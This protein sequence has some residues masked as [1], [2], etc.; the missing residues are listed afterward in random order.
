MEKKKFAAVALDPQYEIFVVYIASLNSVAF[1]S[2]TPLDADIHLFYSNK[3]ADLIAEKALTKVLA[4]YANFTNV[5]SLDLASK[6]PK[7]NR[8]N[9]STI[10]QVNGQKPSSR[11]IYSRRLV[12]L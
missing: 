4:Q 12:E 8:I 6:L 10:K 5:F 3:I 1:F 9:N 11:P 2:F 7:N